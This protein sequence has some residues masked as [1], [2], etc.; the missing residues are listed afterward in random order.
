MFGMAQIS[1]LQFVSL[2]NEFHYLFH[3][4]ICC[5]NYQYLGNAEGR[6]DF[7]AWK[8]QKG[9]CT[10]QGCVQCSQV[11]MYKT[12]PGSQLR[13]QIPSL[14]YKFIDVPPCDIRAAPYESHCFSGI[15]LRPLRKCPVLCKS[16]SST[17]IKG[18]VSQNCPVHADGDI[19]LA[20]C[21]LQS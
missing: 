2:W 8:G 18:T 1:Q 17:L 16:Q 14:I 15:H 20:I 10:G 19:T 3:R 13:T 21:V 6:R 12:F 11:C 5:V 7:T 9:P 4:N